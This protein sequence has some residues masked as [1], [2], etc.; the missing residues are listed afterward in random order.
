MAQGFGFNEWMEKKQPVLARGDLISIRHVVSSQDAYAT[1]VQQSS[2]DTI[3]FR[4]PQ[5]LMRFELLAAGDRVQIMHFDEKSELYLEGCIASLDLQYPW[6]VSVSIDTLR[7]IPNRR[8]EKRCIVN[9]PA[10]IW[11]LD[12]PENR[13]DAAIRNINRKG[14]A[15][16]TRRVLDP[17]TV[18][19]A[20]IFFST[21][22]GVRIEFKGKLVRHDAMERFHLNG[23]EIVRIDEAG[24]DAIDRLLHRLMED[25]RSFVAE[26]LK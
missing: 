17:E 10:R 19:E 20:M 13:I 1:I 23:M 21:P 24:A 26:N 8:A 7:R 14:V 15:L 16:A 12:R 25:E 3:A 9:L 5:D 2:A 6:L 22:E 4:L 18:K 11:L